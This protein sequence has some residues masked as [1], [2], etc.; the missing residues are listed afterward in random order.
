MGNNQTKPN[1]RKQLAAKKRARKRQRQMIIAIV[2]IVCIALIGVFFIN[3]FKKK[4]QSSS[5]NSANASSVAQ[6][7]PTTK[8]KDPDVT[9]DVMM[10]GDMLMHETVIKNGLQAD[11]SYNFDNL[12]ENISSDIQ[13]SDIRIVNQETILGGT[14]LGTSG[15]PAFNSPQELGD[16]EAKAGF[17]V[18]C[19]ATNH[20][21]DRAYRAVDNTIQFWREKHP[22]MAVLGIHD[23][24]EDAQ[25]IYVYEKQGFKVAILNY[26]YGTN[27]IP[28][29]SSAP[30]CVDLMD[31]E[32]E[33]K[34]R[35]DIQKAHTL[36]DMVI[37]CPH[38]GTEYVYRP[39]DFQKYWTDL[40]LEEGVDV[41]IGTHP[42]VLE[43]MDDLVSEGGHRMLVYYSLGN[44]VSD[45]DEIPRMLGGMAKVRL[46]K[47]DGKTSIES[48]SIEPVVTHKRYETGAMTTYKLSDYNDTLA[49]QNKIHAAGSSCY[50]AQFKWCL[51]GADQIGVSTHGANNFSV[52]YCQKLSKYI[53]G[54]YYNY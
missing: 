8:A 10:I 49:S 45:Q 51:C 5:S 38:W 17:N 3:A 29:P 30:Y 1:R 53:L 11:G 42:H 36:A 46:K 27:G 32:H 23:S 22:E 31:D 7:E 35:S 19:H 6:T 14:E 2:S 33:A 39:T 34:V 9:I 16:A 18:V 4:H 43:S 40:F 44:F 41:V 20:T 37:V 52:D 26:T 15:Y 47:S 54:D 24:E 21:I 50:T 12:F 25:N 48:Y 28:V 13:S